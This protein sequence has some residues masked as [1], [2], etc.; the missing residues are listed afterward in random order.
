MTR[1]PGEVKKGPRP[2]HEMPEMQNIRRRAHGGEKA[3]FA[4]TR[5]AALFWYLYL[6]IV[7][8]FAKIRQAHGERGQHSLLPG[9]PPDEFV[10]VFVFTKIRQE[11]AMFPVTRGAT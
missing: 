9:A 11:E 7:F 2:V 4:V 6:Y 10:L 5:R 3:A 1:E 8:V